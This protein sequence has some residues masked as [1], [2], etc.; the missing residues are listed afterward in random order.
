MNTAQPLYDAGHRLVGFSKIVHDLTEQNAAAEVLRESEQKLRLLVEKTQHASLH[1]DL[2]GLANRALFREYLTHAVARYERHPERSFAVLF[3]DLDDFKSVN[4]TYG[5]TLAD[6]LLVQVT[7]R[8]GRAIRTT[9]ILGRLGGDE[10]AILLQD[11]DDTPAAIVTAERVIRRFSV[12]FRIEGNEISTTT[13][14]GITVAS[15]EEDQALKIDDILR[16]ADL[17]MYE[18]KS[19]GGGRY[20]LFDDA[21][22]TR[23]GALLQLDKDVREARER[24]EL[25]ILYQP[26]VDVATRGINGFE[27]V[28]GWQ[29]A[30][31]GFVASA[32]FRAHAGGNGAIIGIDRWVLGEAARQLRTWKGEFDG[33]R[34]LTMS[35]HLSAKE[36]ERPFLIEE[37]L[38]VLYETDL[39]PHSIVVEVTEALTTENADQI[40]AVFEKIR[41]A[42]ID[43][44][45][46]D[47]GSGSSSF[48]ALSRLPIQ[49]LKIDASFTR[50]LTNN[51]KET[52][53]VRAMIALASGLGLKCIATGVST[54]EQFAA[55]A[56]LGCGE[57]QGVLF[58]EPVAADSAREL[59]ALSR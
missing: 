12:P 21:L 29:H 55:L 59:L 25:R 51:G 49:A 17:A 32:Q 22:R 48:V 34:R 26:I 36:F 30:E 8:L 6:Q 43:I 42:G 33:I 35:L 57:A 16:D 11:I 2:T 15:R 45:L 27:A 24:D 19:Q 5:H 44:H 54:E 3:L 41:D 7:R 1:D 13:S 31:H 37:L 46:A 53:V 56:E 58:S 28:V 9:D 39:P 20:V 38:E 18:A 50:A 52:A 40:V 47:F 23:A 14:I 10:F 4:D